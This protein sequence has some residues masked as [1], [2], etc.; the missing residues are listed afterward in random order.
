MSSEGSR[1]LTAGLTL[2]AWAPGSGSA[3]L[4]CQVLAHSD[5]DERRTFSFLGNHIASP[6][7]WL[8]RRVLDRA[9]W[10]SEV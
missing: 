10:V 5:L 6:L 4:G 8:E 2:P 7:F 1:A 9:R 3:R